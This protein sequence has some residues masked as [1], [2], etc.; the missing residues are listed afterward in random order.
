LRVDRLA[1]RQR[2]E[3]LR[4]TLDVAAV[5]INLAEFAGFQ[6]EPATGVSSRE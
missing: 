3:S 2:L 1:A 6:D 4:Q 5:F